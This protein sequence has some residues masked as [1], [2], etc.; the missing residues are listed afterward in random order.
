MKA[1]ILQSLVWTLLMTSNIIAQSG[2]DLNLISNSAY[3]SVDGK[4]HFA[5]GEVITQ[6]FLSSEVKVTSGFY[7]EQL[8]I[9]SI[10][11]TDATIDVKVFP[12]PV[13]AK[14]QIELESTTDY[15]IFVSDMQGRTVLSQI[16]SQSTDIDFSTLSA[17]PYVLMIYN[18]KGKVNSYKIIKN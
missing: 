3:F 15:S 11:I 2:S 8:V 10:G 7:Q 14:L 18:K 17:G 1:I 13:I 12:N 16:I 9:T 5:L 4:Y 6:D